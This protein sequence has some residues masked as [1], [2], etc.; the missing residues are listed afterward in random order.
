MYGASKAAL[1]K[2]TNALAAELHGRGVRVN[3]IEPRA[4]VMSE[5]AEALVGST[6]RADQIEPM[7]AMVEATLALCDCDPDDTG[8]IHVSLDLLAQRGIAVRSLDGA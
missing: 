4:A 6:V 2:L 7:E 5:G 1:N 8:G 3:S